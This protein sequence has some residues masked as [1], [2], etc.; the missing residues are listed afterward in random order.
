VQ[1]G[2]F[3]DWDNVQWLVSGIIVAAHLVF[4]GYMLLFTAEYQFTVQIIRA[5]VF[6][7]SAYIAI[8]ASEFA[9]DAVRE[10]YWRDAYCLSNIALFFAVVWLCLI[11][12]VAWPN[13][14][15]KL[16]N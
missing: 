9:I 15:L 8:G 3:V 16:M 6:I 12:G 1:K 7:G 5:V 14:V 13:F 2:R 10:D 4:G 11:I